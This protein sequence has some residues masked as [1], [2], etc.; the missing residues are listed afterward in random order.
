MSPCLI[1]PVGMYPTL[2]NILCAL[3][4]PFHEKSHNAARMSSP[5]FALS[6]FGIQTLSLSSIL[7]IL[8]T[9]PMSIG[10]NTLGPSSAGTPKPSEPINKTGQAYRPAFG[11]Q[12]E[13]D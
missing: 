12:V 6:P 11:R 7:G 2:I 4:K 8:D 9:F 3:D 1:L 10:D 13:F 5:A